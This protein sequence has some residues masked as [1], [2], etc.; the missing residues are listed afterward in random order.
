MNGVLLAAFI[1]MAIVLVVLGVRYLYHLHPRPCPPSLI[2]CLKN[3][4]AGRYR[5]DVLQRL[6]LSPGMSVLD[7][8]CGPGLLTVPLAR[9]VGPE[10]R[11]TALDIQAAMLE[12]ARAAAAKAGLD[13]ITFLLA[14][15]GEG[16]LPAESFDRAAL[17]TVLGEIP[18]PL[19]A[20]REIHAALKPGGFLSVTEVF[21]DP[22]Y[23]SRKK[24]K[25]LAQEAG[26][27]L[28]NE[29]G[30]WFIFTLNLEKA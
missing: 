28:R 12:R 13:N 9:A 1:V 19:R 21:P 2:G 7:A 17:V 11:V 25:R 30:N 8:G 26:F 16:K 6:E 18:D 10:G 22:D 15:L 3:P 23:Q 29:T 24:V 27:R 4:L 14:G 20:L 5:A